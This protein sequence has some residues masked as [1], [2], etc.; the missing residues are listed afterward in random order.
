M[1]FKKEKPPVDDE[2][3][4]VEWVLRYSDDLASLRKPYK[5]NIDKFVELNLKSVKQELLEH[6][7]K[8]HLST[9]LDS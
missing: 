8:I 3:R 9:G 1:F 2:D 4:F 7:L 5:K 6:K